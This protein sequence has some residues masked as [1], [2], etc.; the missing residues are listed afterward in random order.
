M[1]VALAIVPFVVG[2]GRKGVG[3]KRARR[4]RRGRGEVKEG[5]EGVLLLALSLEKHPSLS[6]ARSTLSLS[7]RPPPRGFVH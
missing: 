6:T 7:L 5:M 1:N 3:G 4:G 2:G